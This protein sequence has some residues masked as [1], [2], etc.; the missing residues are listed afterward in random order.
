M[1]RFDSTLLLKFFLPQVQLIIEGLSDKKHYL[2]EKKNPHE[3][4]IYF[5]LYKFF[6]LLAIVKVGEI[7]TG[8]VLID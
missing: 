3:N 6:P 5:V 4:G 8:L 7:V 1:S 2:H